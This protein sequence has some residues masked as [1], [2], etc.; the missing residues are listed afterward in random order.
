MSET[1]PLPDEPKHPSVRSEPTDLSIRSVMAFLA[2]LAVSLVLIGAGSWGMVVYLTGREAE[3]KRSDSLWKAKDQGGGSAFNVNRETRREELGEDRSR[4]PSLPRLEGIEREPF[5]RE[6]VPPHPGSVQEQMKE[7]DERLA[8]YGW[9]NREKGIVHIP[10][11][12]AM[13]KLAGRLPARDGN[14]INE[15]LD[16]PSR[17]SSGTLPR[18]GKR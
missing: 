16:A 18:G 12:E 3:Q 14:D 17:S 8:G 7:E 1:A 4:L 11:E 6:L 10:I 15:F 9:V 2:G 13:K 5:G